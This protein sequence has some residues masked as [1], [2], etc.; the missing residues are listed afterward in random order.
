M[1]KYPI[2][3]A[4]AA[5]AIIA[6]LMID[7]HKPFPPINDP[8]IVHVEIDEDAAWVEIGKILDK[9]LA[10]GIVKIHI[11]DLFYEYRCAHCIGMGYQGTDPITINPSNLKPFYEWC[12][13]NRGKYPELF[14]GDK[15]EYPAVEKIFSILNERGFTFYLKRSSGDNAEIKAD[16]YD[17]RYECEKT[18]E[19][20]KLQPTPLNASDEVE[21]QGGASEL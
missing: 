19:P 2:I 7:H 14:F 5:I 15:V 16:L 11:N 12:N 21:T 17:G 6:L 18:K 4:I 13:K 3:L 1:K 8:Y 10:E 20:K 9:F